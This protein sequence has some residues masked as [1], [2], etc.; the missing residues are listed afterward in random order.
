MRKFGRAA[1]GQA[2]ARWR[3]EARLDARADGQVPQQLT[4][5]FSIDY[6][7]RIQWAIAKGNAFLALA[8]GL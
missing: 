8:V 3:R 4:K 2:K 6:E 7:M 5:A 1:L